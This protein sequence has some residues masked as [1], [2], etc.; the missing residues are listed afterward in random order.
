MRKDPVPVV[1]AFLLAT[2]AGSLARPARAVDWDVEAI[3]VSQLKATKPSVDPEA[4]VEALLWDTSVEEAQ[5]GNEPQTRYRHFLRL[6]VYNERGV[7]SLKQVDIPFGNDVFVGDIEARTT[8]PDGSEIELQ[9]K[10]VFERTL[11]KANGLKVKVKSFAIPGLVPGA[12]VDYHWHETHIKEFAHDVVLDLQR[13]VPVLKVRHHVKPSEMAQDLGYSMSVRGF[14]Q[15][16]P[17]GEQDRR[18][19]TTFTYTNL[20][21]FKEEPFMPPEYMLRRWMLIYYSEDSNVQPQKFWRKRAAKLFDSFKPRKPSR[22]VQDALAVAG[23]AASSPAETMSRLM[24]FCRG[25][26]KRIDL[27]SSGLTPDERKKLSE[28]EDSDDTLAHAYGTGGD[29]IRLFLDLAGAAGLDARAA[30]LPD[31]SFHG[32]EPGF[33]NGYFLRSL[34]VAVRN[35]DGWLFCDPAATYLPSGMLRWQEEGQIALIGDPDQI[36]LIATPNAEPDRSLARREA[37]LRV[38]EDGTV[39]GEV[40]EE[41][42]GHLA[43]R[44]KNANDEKSAAE[45][46]EALKEEVKKRLSTAELSEV[47]FENVKDPER[48]LKR[49][50][51]VRVPNYAQRT[52]RRI[53]FQPS[54]FEK[55]AAATFPASKREHPILFPFA[56][57]QEDHVTVEVPPGFTFEQPSMPAGLKSEPVASYSTTARILNG[58]TL[59]YARQFKF[60]GKGSLFFPADV[61]PALKQFFDALYEADNHTLTL[62]QGAP[63]K[64]AAP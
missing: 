4:D 1:V 49:R 56:W 61:Y 62:S 35:G 3:E 10:D 48:P 47:V 8:R 60:G 30:S 34:S 19:F 5:Q 43:S 6:K 20:P 44:L 2:T 15:P 52:G 33:P 11:V 13:N 55:G 58:T 37:K 50:Y 41:F 23:G 28:N 27:D 38:S 53:F 16:V 36:L 7:E 17:Q 9:G 40:T 31:G 18:G 14:N 25:K 42:T 51:H 32:F 46:T 57:S 12:I 24:A 22:A 39:E 21:A 54:F 64:T 59:D 45:Q 26:I 29:V 63:A